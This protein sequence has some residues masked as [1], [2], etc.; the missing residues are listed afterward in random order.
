MR[1]SLVALQYAPSQWLILAAAMLFLPWLNSTSKLIANDANQGETD[2]AEQNK[3]DPAAPRVLPE[4]QVVPPSSPPSSTSNA[5]TRAPSI[6][7]T[8]PAVPL[9]AQSL[10]SNSSSEARSNNGA[11]NAN[12]MGNLSSGQSL[13]ETMTPRAGAITGSSLTVIGKQAITNSGQR[14]LSELL[15][16]VPGVDVVQSGGPGQQTSVFLR[17][18]N[19]N[20]VKVL[21]DG[22]P[23]NDP[24]SPGRAF[25]FSALTTDQIERVEVLRGPQ[26]TIYGSDAIGG[27]INIITSAGGT[28]GSRIGVMG[29]RYD[30]GQV[31]GSRSG[32]NED[33]TYSVGGSYLYTDGFSAARIA[34]GNQENDGYRNTSASGRMG[35]KLTENTKLDFTVRHHRAETEIDEFAFVPPVGFIP[36]DSNGLLTQK[37]TF[38][39][40]QS[41]SSFLDGLWVSRLGAGYSQYD[42]AS[43]TA[44][45]GEFY[46]RTGRLDWQN[47]L[48]LVQDKDFTTHLI[49]GL[50]YYEEIGR[51]ANV[52]RGRQDDE[53]YYAQM[54]FDVWE[55]WH[56]SVGTRHDEYSLAGPADTWRVTSR[57]DLLATDSAI[58]GAMGTGFRAPAIEELFNL[59]F[60]GNPL[61]RPERS[62][63]WEAG[64]QQNLVDD[65]IIVD[66]TYFRN[67][68]NDLITFVFDPTL[69]FFGRLENVNRA[70][71]TGVEVTSLWR[72][73]E[74][75]TSYLNYTRTDSRDRDTGDPLPRRAR[76][77]W[78]TG[79]SWTD[80]AQRKNITTSASFVGFR[81]DFGNIP[82]DHYVLLNVAG[83]YQMTSQ[84]RWLGRIDNLLDQKYD[85][86]FGYQNPGASLFVGAEWSH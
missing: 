65:L 47:D 68:F 21:I 43:L 83:W 81:T 10:P 52:P 71:A 6:N 78:Q 28:P 40:V 2:T 35:I 63:G 62:R 44:F 74:S 30:T 19:S 69:P 5:D 18:A 61:L 7:S 51:S 13:S 3:T 46:G 42:R 4:V 24:V 20:Q 55:R 76:D 8:S 45:G 37:N 17:G 9:P 84:W 29:G 32:G 53:A 49:A 54:T 41:T 57:W 66:V 38:S 80:D 73:S 15:R 75:V 39:R 14:Q 67:D 56:T 70:L 11:A 34:P 12:A 1:N 86:I 31:Y 26:S 23:A 50:D 59:P 48:T 60:G 22:V 85:E 72:W 25:D 16:Q 79:I 27:V 82:L 33:V 64:W 77:K 58:H 36:Q